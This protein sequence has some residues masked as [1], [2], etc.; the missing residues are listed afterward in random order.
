MGC[1]NIT[2]AYMDLDNLNSLQVKA[3]AIP[4]YKKYKFWLQACM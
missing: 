1:L 4:V 3:L 2:T